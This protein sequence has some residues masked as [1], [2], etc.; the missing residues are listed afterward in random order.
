MTI[1]RLQGQSQ[2][3]WVSFKDKGQDAC[4]LL[5]EPALFLSQQS[6]N[7][8][9][10]RAIP[11]DQKDL[12]IPTTYLQQ[13]ADH[14][15]ILG[16]S[17]WLN[18]C[19]IKMDKPSSLESVDFISHIAPYQSLKA[20]NSTISNRSTDAVSQHF[21]YG[22]AYFQ[23]RMIGIPEI[24]RK[25]LSG[26]GITIGVFDGGFGGVDTMKVFDSLFSNQQL[27][28][29]Y[30]FVD[31]EQD[32]FHSTN[33]DF[34]VHGTQVLS[35]IGAQ[36]PGKLIGTAPH[37][38]FI[39]ARTEDASSESRQEELNWIMAMEWADSIG[40]DIIHSS[41][42]YS[43]FD[44]PKENYTYEDMNGRTTKITI[45]ADIAASKGIIITTGAGNRGHEA[46]KYITAPCD[47][48]SVLCVGAIDLNKE[49]AWFS[50]FGPS[51]DG[52][53][54]PDVVALGQGVW[55]ATPTLGLEQKNGTS[56]SSPL[57]AG[58]AA[59][60]LQAYP[61]RHPYDIVQ[62]IR[63]SGNQR[64]DPS[65]TQGF[66]LPHARIADSVLRQNRNINAIWKQTKASEKKGD[67]GPRIIEAKDAKST[68]RFILN[69]LTIKT[70]EATIE[71]VNIVFGKQKLFFPPDE[72]QIY[73]KIARFNLEYLLEGEYILEIKTNKYQ[74]FIKFS[75]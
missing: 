42:S 75:H 71:E 74:E 27:I 33:T 32:I 18:A 34:S 30:D 67:T 15:Q 72:V 58:M 38:N 37:A 49:R 47:G 13:L 1:P 10:Q 53:T 50:S 44:D 28:A 63:W 64:D 41:L 29:Y 3:Y 22:K 54:K 36:Y 16:H 2:M 70:P 14:G 59:C 19:L 12:P 73:P 51:A 7:R 35:V 66:G 4:H 68:I 5:Q 24:H 17:K 11:I 56:L 48:D 8:K 25:G 40:V 52:R 23:N 6:I 45:A 9:R 43:N 60:L 65:P 55:V 31:K 26:T 69:A 39:L 21:S 57:I 20:F 46:W 61:K 62:A